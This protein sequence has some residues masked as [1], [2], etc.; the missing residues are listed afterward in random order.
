MNCK[1]CGTPL[2]GIE[3]A[4]PMCGAKLPEM[5]QPV[6]GQMMPGMQGQ[7]PGMPQPMPGMTGGMMPQQMPAMPQQPTMPQMTPVGVGQQPMAMGMMPE[8]P[9]EEVKPKKDNKMFL[10][11]LAVVAV[12]AIGVGIF[13]MLTDE[14]E[15]APTPS[16]SETEYTVPTLVAETYGGYTF[17][18]P[19]GYTSEINDTYGLTIKNTNSIFTIGVDYTNNYEYYKTAF[20]GAFPTEAANMVKTF[21]GNEYVAA[22]L[23]DTEGANGTEYMTSTSDALG[24]FVGMVVRS[25]FSPPTEAEFTTLNDII[26]GAIKQ[27][28][29]NPGDADDIGKAGIRNYIPLFSKTQF[30]FS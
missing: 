9:T 8:Q 6:P 3:H 2:S 22:I 27:T 18:I 17:T 15:Q 30:V 19:S 20:Q 11:L 7:M 25:D 16:P 23:T 10:I 26:T 12:A 5:P 21:G 14:E 28:V 24:T 13:L 4:C 29:V 1:N